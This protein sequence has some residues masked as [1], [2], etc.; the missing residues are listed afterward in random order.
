MELNLLGKVT[1]SRLFFFSD[2][3]CWKSSVDPAAIKFCVGFCTC[4]LICYALF[5]LRGSQP[6]LYVPCFSGICPEFPLGP[7]RCRGGFHSRG[8]SKWSLLSHTHDSASWS[9]ILQRLRWQCALSLHG[10][11]VVGFILNKFWYVEVKN[12]SLVSRESRKWRFARICL[13]FN[14]L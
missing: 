9:V 4:F 5:Y 13:I 6:K 10:K 12:K 11:C 1:D 8:G 14:C 7:A 2:S 3:T